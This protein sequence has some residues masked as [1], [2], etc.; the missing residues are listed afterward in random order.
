MYPEIDRRP[1]WPNELY[2]THAPPEPLDPPVRL[3]ATTWDAPP[4]RIQNLA[5]WNRLRGVLMGGL[6]MFVGVGMLARSPAGWLFV[7]MGALL[8]GSAGLDVW[9]QFTD[10]SGAEF[11]RATGPSRVVDRGGIHE[12]LTALP[13]CLALRTART[14]A[15]PPT[16]PTSTTGAQ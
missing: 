5:W 11:L 13:C 2:T 3:A 15:A 8:V 10:E 7:A 9:R 4:E 16:P 1:L 12:S 6:C 14:G